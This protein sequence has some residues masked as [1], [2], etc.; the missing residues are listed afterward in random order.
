VRDGTFFQRLFAMFHVSTL[1]KPSPCLMITRS[2]LL[3]APYPPLLLHTNSSWARFSTCLGF[4]P[5]YTQ[6]ICARRLRP[7]DEVGIAAHGSERVRR[8]SM[9]AVGP[10]PAS[11]Q[12]DS[13]VGWQMRGGYLAG[14]RLAC[15]PGLQ[16]VPCS[17]SFIDKHAWELSEMFARGIKP[18][19]HILRNRIFMD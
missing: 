4:T 11:R 5:C 17:G 3:C 2:L 16:L 8:E 7:G 9:V 13:G 15:T 6:G 18:H 19:R 12:C 10:R 1:E 14:H